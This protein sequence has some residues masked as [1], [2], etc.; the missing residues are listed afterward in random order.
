MG[1]LQLWDITPA[2]STSLRTNVHVHKVVVKPR[3]R[4]QNKCVLPV[5]EEQAGGAAT[6]AAAAAAAWSKRQ[7]HS[8][9]HTKCKRRCNFSN[10]AYI[11]WTLLFSLMQSD[12]KNTD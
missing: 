2:S 4:E 1:R 6:P 11:L 3:R 8:G 10:L 7:I 9:K 5:L 12:R